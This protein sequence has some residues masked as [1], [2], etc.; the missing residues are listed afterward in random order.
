MA[1]NINGI[2][3]Y[4]G[5]SQLWDMPKKK[6]KFKI[7][8]G[9]IL[10]DH[11][12][13][14]VKTSILTGKNPEDEDFPWTVVY[15]GLDYNGDDDPNYERTALHADQGKY[16]YELIQNLTNQ[17]NSIS[18]T[19]T[20]TGDESNVLPVPASGHTG[21]ECLYYY[22][23][24][25]G[26]VGDIEAYITNEYGQHAQCSI[27]RY[28]NVL[29][30]ASGRI[31][32]KLNSTKN[33]HPQDY[34]LVVRSVVNNVE[35]ARAESIIRQEAYVR[36]VQSMVYVPNSASLRYDVFTKDGGYVYP[37]FTGL[38]NVTYDTGEIETN[39]PFVLN[40]SFVKTTV[41]NS[42]LID[43]V[44]LESAGIVHAPSTSESTLHT[45]GTVSL[46]CRIFDNNPE[47]IFNVSAVVY[48]AG[49]NDGVVKVDPMYITEFG[50]PENFPATINGSKSI[51]P[52]VIIKQR[53][54]YV[55]GI[56]TDETV[57]LSTINATF[58]VSPTTGIT[59][60][61]NTGVITKTSSN[62]SGS[63]L[64]YR[65]TM[66]I[67]NNV[68][69]TEHSRTIIVTQPSESV[70]VPEYGDVTVTFTYPKYANNSAL[71]YNFDYDG[72]ATASS[73]DSAPKITKV[74]QKYGSSTA[75]IYTN[76]ANDSLQQS[77]SKAGLSNIRFSISSEAT[78][79][80]PTIDPLTGVVTGSANLEGSKTFTVTMT[81]SL[82]GV[83]L[84]NC[85]TTLQQ[86]T[87]NKY[88]WFGYSETTP[89]AFG[90]WTHGEQKEASKVYSGAE[91]AKVQTI[92]DQ[93]ATCHWIMIP[94]DSAYKLSAANNQ[95]GRNM[96]EIEGV[97]AEILPTASNAIKDTNYRAYYMWHY[98]D[99]LYIQAPTIFV[100]SY[101]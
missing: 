1:D 11:L 57:N 15:N 66:T 75:T 78:I 2:E 93:H 24:A 30:T 65:I 96:M 40:D 100:L 81:G 86:D 68:N 22:F 83:A 7:N 32:V 4:L 6:L 9:A 45:L 97:G 44:T 8:D 85:T 59:I 54:Y 71:T 21:N 70:P 62:Q 80:L 60:D 14:Q 28:D 92:A 47:N 67:P 88:I 74:T 39:V 33:T 56:S 69:I 3:K 53:V 34:V 16:L 26:A 98:T 61:P 5:D 41:W 91:Q 76:T 43:G 18:P 29:G 82:N 84:K 12:S 87:I 64:S 89:T 51:T 58:S 94:K 20:L 23:T 48:Q 17:I 55:S 27:E 25:E 38:V 99:N 36:Q 13:D 77:I 19:I 72:Y 35:N 42:D 63:T 52:S 49:V 79:D 31:T 50:Y 73:K 46:V 95:L 10:W 90:T 37:T 101:K